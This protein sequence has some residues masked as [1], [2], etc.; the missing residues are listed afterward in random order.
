M[1]VWEVWR[2]RCLVSVS[3]CFEAGTSADYAIDH[4][5]LFGV[6]GG[7]EDFVIGDCLYTPGG[8]GHRR[9]PY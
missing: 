5:T 9:I 3:T 8:E 7:L 2:V 4:P 6:F 1:E